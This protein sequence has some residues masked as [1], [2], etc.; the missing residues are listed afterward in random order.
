MGDGAPP[1]ARRGRDPPRAP[2]T[3]VGG[4]PCLPGP[5]DTV[6]PTR[7]ASTASSRGGSSRPPGGDAAPARAEPGTGR[8][9]TGRL[10][11][12]GP[13]GHPAGSARPV[14]PR[15][16]PPG[17]NGRTGG[18]LGHRGG[19]GGAARKRNREGGAHGGR[20]TLVNLSDKSTAPSLFSLHPSTHAPP[21]HS[22]LHSGVGNARIEL[23]RAIPRSAE[24]LLLQQWPP[25]KNV[26]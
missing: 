22:K 1:A 13:S 20:W 14:P 19:A 6:A 25:E 18:G 4:P 23:I 10:A 16:P 2:P 7:R 3:G 11:R 8:G 21:L 5:G 17:I 15:K 12:R 24:A 9:G 26:V